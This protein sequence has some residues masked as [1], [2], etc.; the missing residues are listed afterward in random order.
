[1][2]PNKDEGLDNVECNETGKCDEG[3]RAT[4]SS[5]ANVQRTVVGCKV[6][7]FVIVGI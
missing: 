3:S 5:I 6:S 4:S 7:L 2:R 1:M